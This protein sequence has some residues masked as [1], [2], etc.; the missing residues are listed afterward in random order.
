MDYIKETNFPIIPSRVLC[1]P[2]LALSKMPVLKLSQ[3][4]HI[5]SFP[6]YDLSCWHM[7]LLMPCI[8]Y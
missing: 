7:Y 1:Q 8:S 5:Y 4:G 2:I 3:E 6:D